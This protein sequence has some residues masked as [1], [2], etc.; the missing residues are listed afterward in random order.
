MQSP[1]QHC[2]P[3]AVWPVPRCNTPKSWGGEGEN[4]VNRFH[5][6]IYANTLAQVNGKTLFIHV[7]LTT[8]TF[9]ENAGGVDSRRSCQPQC[10]YFLGL[11]PLLTRTLGWLDLGKS[12]P[13]DATL[14][15]YLVYLFVGF[16]ISG[17]PVPLFPPPWAPLGPRGFFHL[18][19]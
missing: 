2:T 3:H 14:D 7:C 4:I 13:S 11:R 5:Q 19:T 12:H 1:R 17:P 18:S 9:W 6:T 16:H 8:V 15:R 10:P